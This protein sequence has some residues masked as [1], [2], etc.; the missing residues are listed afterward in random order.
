MKRG[1]IACIFFA[2][3]VAVASTQAKMDKDTANENLLGIALLMAICVLVWWC[4]GDMRNKNLKCKL[5]M[6]DWSG[7]YCTK[8]GKT[9]DERHD[10]KGCKC[11]ACGK[12]RDEGHDWKGCRCLAC[13][14]TRD[15]GHDWDADG[16][17]KGCWTLRPHNCAKLGHKWRESG[18]TGG[19]TLNHFRVTYSCRICGANKDR[20][21]RDDSSVNLYNH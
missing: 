16:W 13:R 7:C 15:E 20:D 8:C 14:K 19:T 2:A 6:H 1:V 3:V 17:C 12:T 4:S 11:L 9:R 10:W 5:G 18:H 21:D